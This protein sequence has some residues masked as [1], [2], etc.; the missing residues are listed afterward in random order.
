MTGTGRSGVMRSVVV[1]TTWNAMRPAD[2]WA[3][4]FAAFVRPRLAATSFAV[5]GLPS[6]NRRS[7]RSL[8][9]QLRPPSGTAD[10]ASNGTTRPSRSTVNRASPTPWVV[11]DQPLAPRPGSVPPAMNVWPTTM[12]SA[13]MAGAVAKASDRAPAANAARRR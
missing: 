9:S 12:R 13:A 4:G 11:S 8:T 10:A 6:A 7:G 3:A 5:T 2:A 1:S